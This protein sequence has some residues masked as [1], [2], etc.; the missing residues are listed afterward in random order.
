MNFLIHPFEY[1]LNAGMSRN[2]LSPIA[3][4]C[5]SD[6]I[7][8]LETMR[9]ILFHRNSIG[10]RSGEYGGRSTSL[11][12]RSGALLIFMVQ[13]QETVTL[14]NY[15]N[16]VR[17]LNYFQVGLL[18]LVNGLAVVATQGLVYK[19]IG[20]IGNY[21]SFIIGSIVYSAGFLSFGFFSNLSGMLIA[22]LI[23]TIGKDFAFPA[24]AAMVSLISK[25]ENIGKSI[26]LYNAFISV[27]RAMGP[28][29]GGAVLSITS[30]PFEI[31][32]LATLSGFLSAAVFGFY[33]RGRR[34]IQENRNS[35][36]AG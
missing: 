15:A 26:G 20:R 17:G 14:S 2:V 12:S 13:A 35:E 23:L 24:S 30:V 32:G 29:V 16:I 27:A 4:K 3:F 10:L 5:I 22:T 8:V 11:K 28:L 36:Q 18:Y 9:F 21:N 1:E 7:I 33:F 25:P 34:E 31:W 6:A 19:V